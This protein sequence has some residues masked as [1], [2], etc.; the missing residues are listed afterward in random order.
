MRGRVKGLMYI[1]CDIYTEA[2]N[3]NMVT[4]KQERRQG[5][6]FSRRT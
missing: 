2:Y 4:V 3:E 6:T 5:T 1:S